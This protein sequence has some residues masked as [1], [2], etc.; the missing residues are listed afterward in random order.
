MVG[1]AIEIGEYL[2]IERLSFVQRHGC[3]FGTSYNGAGE[4]EG[5]DGCRSAR[6]NKAFQ[7]REAGVHDVDVAFQPLD[8]RADDAQRTLDLSGRRDVGAEI[9]QVVLNLGILVS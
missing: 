2:R 6:K 7:R 8:L 9:E 5:G 3:A 1:Q 4:V